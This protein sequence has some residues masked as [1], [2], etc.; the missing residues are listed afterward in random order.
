MKSKKPNIVTKN[1][2]LPTSVVEVIENTWSSKSEDSKDRFRNTAAYRIVSMIYSG[3]QS[4]NY[5]VAVPSKYYMKLFSSVY[6][7]VMQELINKN[8]V[9]TFA[10]ETSKASYITT[11]TAKK[12]SNNPKAKGMSK[13]FRVSGNHYIPPLEL[14]D[15]LG[16]NLY[17]SYKSNFKKKTKNKK[18]SPSKGTGTVIEISYTPKRSAE[19]Y[20]EQFIRD[21]SSIVIDTDKLEK[22]AK[23]KVDSLNASE[24]IVDTNTAQGDEFYIKV[25][26][27]NR[28]KKNYLSYKL[29]NIKKEVIKDGTSLFKDKDMYYVGTIEQF[30]EYKRHNMSISYAETINS[31][32]NAD[33]YAKRNESNY[34]LDTNLTNM[35]N[36]MLD[37]LKEDNNLVSLDLMNSQ[38]SILSYILEGTELKDKE[39]FKK[40]KEECYSGQIY[41]NVS[42]ILNISRKEAKTGFFEVLFGRVGAE[43][44]AKNLLKELYPNVIEWTDQ[45]KKKNSYKDLAKLLQRKESEMFIDNIFEILTKKGFFVLTKHDSVIVKASDEEK[46]THEIIKYFKSIGFRGKMKKE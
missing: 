6:T 17:L 10:S 30:T 5:Y 24:Y 29:G 7:G 28:S 32:K 46:V 8:V 42:S 3:Q 36:F 12:Y 11:E 39:D 19:E 34:R 16:T 18:K 14:T 1:I 26:F 31:L 15:D 23:N 45:Y 13:K 22:E 37:I 41:D 9:E 43:Y 40:F 27:L 33:F 35:P 38:L 21:I 2:L 44:K 4:E 20:E 25:I